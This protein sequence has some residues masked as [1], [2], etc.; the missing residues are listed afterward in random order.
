MHLRL[1][2]WHLQKARD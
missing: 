1:D 2:I